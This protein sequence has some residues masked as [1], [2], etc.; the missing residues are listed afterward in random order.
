M[1]HRLPATTSLLRSLLRHAA[2]DT[3]ASAPALAKPLPAMLPHAASSSSL[4][5]AAAQQQPRRAA[6]SS[7]SPSPAAAANRLPPPRARK[8]AGYVWSELMFWHNPGEIGDLATRVQPTRHLEHAET[9]RRLHNL[10]ELSG[11]LSAA[12]LAGLAAAAAPAASPAPSPSPSAA[13]KRRR[14][15]VAGPALVEIEPRVAT[16]AELER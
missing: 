8:P 12:P 6:A 3:H 2:L 5:G 15:P 16:I 14:Q 9:K 7:S 10:V 1:A 4:S 13:S 11:L